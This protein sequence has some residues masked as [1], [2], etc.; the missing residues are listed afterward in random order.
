MSSGQDGNG[1]CSPSLAEQISQ[2]EKLSRYKRRRTSI[3]PKPLSFL[4]HNEVP[5]LHFCSLIMGAEVS[6]VGTTLEYPRWEN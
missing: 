6:E 4:E 2:P 1:L 3:L 5:V